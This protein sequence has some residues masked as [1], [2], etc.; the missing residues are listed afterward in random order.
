MMPG[1]TAAGAISE[2]A[3]RLR[4]AGCDSPVRDAEYLLC[5]ALHTDRAGL[6]SLGSAAIPDGSLARFREMV[7]RRYSREPLQHIAGST[8][9]YGLEFRCGPGALVPRP[10][11]EILL[12]SFVEALPGSPGLLLDVGTGSGV[13]AV[14]LATRFPAATVVATDVTAESLA[15]AAANARLHNARVFFV[16]S[17][18]LA[19][20]DAR[21][22]G[23]VANLPY[24][25]GQ[26]IPG[27]QPEVRLHDPL[28]ALDGGVDGLALILRLVRDAPRF[29]ASGGVLA[30]EAAGRQPFRISRMLEKSG[31]WRDIRRGTDLAGRPRW[32]TAIRN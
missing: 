27:I 5:I 11:T 29:L 24:I 28:I 6:Y 12:E 26:D 30:L 13:L 8:E 10:E 15:I 20:L 21:F 16:R 31:A 3:R 23:I 7:E 18:L 17:D 4:E 19:A 22:D 2:A 1:R 14:C 25:R 32:V 9:F